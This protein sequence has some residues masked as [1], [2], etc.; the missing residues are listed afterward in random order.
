MLLGGYGCGKTHLA[1]AIAN[2]VIEQGQP[3]L[4]VVVPDLLD[5]LRA[6]FSPASGISLDKRFEEV[7]TPDDVPAYT[8]KFPLKRME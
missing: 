8:S 3:A 4:F 5:H 7:K 2:H 1:A 6:S